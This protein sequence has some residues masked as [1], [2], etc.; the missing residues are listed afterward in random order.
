[1]DN[2]TKIF[3]KKKIKISRNRISFSTKENDFLFDEINK[4][5]IEKLFFIKRKFPNVLEIGSRFGKTL[6]IY[7]YKK[8]IKKFFVTDI[9]FEMLDK[10]KNKLKKDKKKELFYFLNIDE[11]KIPIDKEKLNL[12]ISNLYLH[13]SNDI[14]STFSEIYRILKA[15]GLFLG[16]IFGNDTLKELKYS[17]YTAENKILKKVTPR[18]SPFIKMQDAGSLLQKSGFQLPVIDRDVIKIFFKD[19]YSLMKSIRGMG[20][21]NSLIERKKNFTQKKIL[22]LANEIYLKNFSEN[23]KIYATF[24]ILY[25]TGWTKHSTQQKPLKPGSAKEKLEDFL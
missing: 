19:I 11:E 12:V 15:D 6:E 20:E 22:D 17:V 18:V 3:S 8:D 5:L 7:P 25:L 24:E 16:S 1:M 23:N 10:E 9:S 13:W 14:V 4:R 2:K 21:S